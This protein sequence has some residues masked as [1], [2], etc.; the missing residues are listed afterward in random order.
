MNLNS[1]TSVFVAVAAVIIVAA[2]ASTLTVSPAGLSTTTAGGTS[3]YGTSPDGLQLT[4]QI[5]NSQVQQGGT[6]MI[7]VSETNTNSKPLNESAAG[8]WAVEGLRMSACYASVYPF[9]V[10]VYQGHLTKDTLTPS[11]RLNLYPLVPCPLLIRYVSGYY[12]QGASD[13]ALVLPGTGPGIPM[14]SGLAVS[15]NY[16]TGSSRTSFS[17][18]EYTV[19][20]G[21]EW[22]SLVFLYFTVG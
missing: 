21:D 20:A 6:L 3:T 13:V 8:S 18:G 16:T 9:G 7:N 17:P 15:G 12:F 14:A 2:L 1:N 10:A 22:G 4:L 11:D 19:V 5:S